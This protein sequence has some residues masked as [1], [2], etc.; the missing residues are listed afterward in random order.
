MENIFNDDFK[1][2][3]IALN[4]NH[5]E[6]ILVGGYAVILHG[7][8]RNTGDIDLWVNST[9][10]NFLNLIKAFNQFGLPTLSLEM[11]KFLDTKNFEVFSYGRPPVAIDIM[12]SVKG[13]DFNSAFANAKKILVNDVY[14]N[15]ID[16]RDLIA[17]KKASAR[18]KDMNDIQDLNKS[19]PDKT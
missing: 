18:L 3:L 9:E 15:L 4:N 2:F 1:D 8:S 7:S 16:Y 10:E 19:N 11:E 17:A 5:V 6:Y 14:V 12:T 13:L